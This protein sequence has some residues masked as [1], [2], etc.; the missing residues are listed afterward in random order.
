[1]SY[2]IQSIHHCVIVYERDVNKAYT[3]IMC[4]RSR[5]STCT[6]KS[7][8]NLDTAFEIRTL[9]YQC[10]GPK[11]YYYLYKLRDSVTEL[12]KSSALARIC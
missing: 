5:E 12:L 6:S 3:V 4:W 9:I 11:V 2:P 10:F 1:M 7:R 8:N